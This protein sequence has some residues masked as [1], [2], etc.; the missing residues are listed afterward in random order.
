MTLLCS[1]FGEHYHQERPH[2]GLSNE[3]IGKGKTK[4]KSAT[5]A[6]TIRLSEIRCKERLGGLLKSYSRRAA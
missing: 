2:Q 4:Q 1:E 5:P 3:V 6:D